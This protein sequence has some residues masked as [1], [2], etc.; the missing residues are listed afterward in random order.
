MS[1]IERTDQASHAEELLDQ[2]WFFNH[3]L[4]IDLAY[5]NLAVAKNCNL[6]FFDVLG[7]LQI[8][9]YGFVFDLIIGGAE[10]EI[11]DML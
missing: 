3:V 10:L 8:Y 5:Y 7:E 9:C 11:Q 2:L 6:S 4:L 1:I